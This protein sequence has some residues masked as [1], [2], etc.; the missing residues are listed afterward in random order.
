MTLYGSQPAARFAAT[1]TS[2]VVVR[3]RV[4]AP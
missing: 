3:P 1:G 4:C 2:V